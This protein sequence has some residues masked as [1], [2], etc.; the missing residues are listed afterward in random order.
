MKE[1]E[2]DPCL[3][4]GERASET[5]R[6][7]GQSGSTRTQTEGPGEAQGHGEERAPL[8]QVGPA[9]SREVTVHKQIRTEPDW[10]SP[11]SWGLH[12]DIHSVH[13]HVSNTYWVPGPVDDAGDAEMRRHEESG[14]HECLVW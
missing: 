1:E 5:G 4:G 10:A 3:E 6:R 11:E 13:K 7:Q 12:F 14:T 2:G 8:S 9:G